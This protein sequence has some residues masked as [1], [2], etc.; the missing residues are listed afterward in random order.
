MNALSELKRLSELTHTIVLTLQH[1]TAH[2]T[3]TH[4]NETHCNTL[5]HTTTHC[6]NK[7]LIDALSELK[8]LP[9]LTHKIVLD[10]IRLVGLSL[11]PWQLD[12]SHVTCCCS[13]LQ[14]VA[15]CC[16]VLQCVTMDV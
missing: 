1:T 14:C 11:Q 3:E 4:C 2:C 15:V 6:N 10:A 16:S 7:Q 8:R 12:V 9:E 13:V 5:Q